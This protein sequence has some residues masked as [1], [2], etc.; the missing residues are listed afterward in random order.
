MKKVTHK[1]QAFTLIELLVVI[2]IIAILAAMLLPA[3]AAARAKAQRITCASNL[4][5][6]SVAFAL[7]AGDNHDY[8]PMA[9]CPCNFYNSGAS[10]SG[11]EEAVGQPGTAATQVGNYDPSTFGGSQPKC[12]G[13][14]SMFL[15]MSNQLNTPKILSCPTESVDTHHF[16]SVTWNGVPAVGVAG[17]T[18]DCNVSYF[19][20]VDASATGGMMQGGNARAPLSGDRFMGNGTIANPPT[21][22]IF[23][24]QVLTGV[25]SFCQPLGL[26]NAINKNAVTPCWASSVGHGLSGNVAMTDAS[27]SS[28]TTPS[29]WSALA[30]SG[31]AN[32]VAGDITGLGA[33]PAGYNRLQ[34]P[35]TY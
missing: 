3:L 5:Q 29:L 14:F 26:T 16:Q 6:I 35:A 21:T 12:Y 19:I 27:V 22:N 7:Y 15:A 1:I 20:A 13:V 31:D 23:E 18:N 9:T 11:A 17:Y 4:K 10:K 2:A 24:S 33:F 30:N 32:H 28:F 25:A 34:F 8:Y